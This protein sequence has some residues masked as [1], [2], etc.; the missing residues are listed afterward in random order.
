MQTYDPGHVYLCQLSTSVSGLCWKY[1]LEAIINQLLL[2][3]LVHDNLYY[4]CQNCIDRK[5]RYMCGYIDNTM[6]LVSLQLTSS[7]I[8]RQSWFPDYGHWM[9][10]ITGSHHQENDVMDKTHPLAQH[11]IV[12]FIATAFLMS[13]TYSF[14]H[15]IM[16]LPDTGGIP[17]VLSNVTT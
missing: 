2:Y 17:Y 4:P 1:A 13:N 9:S 15:E 6:S 5:L 7:L 3:F 10:L 14:D 11:M 16:Q 12:Q 8:N